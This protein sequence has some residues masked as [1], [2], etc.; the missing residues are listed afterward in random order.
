MTAAKAAALW[1]GVEPPLPR[2][3]ILG[4]SRGE[5]YLIE[6]VWH[7]NGSMFDPKS[8]TEKDTQAQ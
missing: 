8:W 6:R 4:K 5:G 7:V 3:H 1:T 2:I